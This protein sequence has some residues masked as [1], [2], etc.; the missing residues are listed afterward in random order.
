[1]I[2]ILTLNETK[3]ATLYE[4]SF[5]PRNEISIVTEYIFNPVFL[6]VQ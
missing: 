2:K 1:M 6:F 5:Q 3:R 4:T